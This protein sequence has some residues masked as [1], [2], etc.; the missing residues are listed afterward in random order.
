MIQLEDQYHFSVVPDGEDQIV[1]CERCGDELKCGGIA[2]LADLNAA[3][4]EHVE[5]CP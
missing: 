1:I 5:V 3:A 4:S 2:M